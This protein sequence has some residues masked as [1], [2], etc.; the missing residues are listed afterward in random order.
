MNSVT[1]SRIANSITTLLI[2]EILLGIH[3]FYPILLSIIRWIR[4]E[5][6]IE[7]QTSSKDI[8]TLLKNPDVHKLFIEFARNEWSIG[9]HEYWSL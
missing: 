9:N 6:K 1:S 8:F 2:Y 4:Q 7:K 3:A 5:K